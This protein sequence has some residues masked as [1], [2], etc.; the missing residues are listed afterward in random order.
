M[1]AGITC[2]Q[3]FA[4]IYAWLFTLGS[5]IRCEEGFLLLPN[6]RLKSHLTVN[7]IGLYICMK[8]H[9]LKLAHKLRSKIGIS[10][11]ACIYLLLGGCS[12]LLTVALGKVNNTTSHSW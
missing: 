10:R 3:G 6:D 11:N 2:R 9:V 8:N 4:E 7:F 1:G 5:N 12:Y